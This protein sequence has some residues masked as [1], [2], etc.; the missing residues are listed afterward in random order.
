MAGGHSQR[1]TASTITFKHIFNTEE[2]PIEPL[3]CLLNPPETVCFTLLIWLSF[4]LLQSRQIPR[5]CS[6]FSCVGH[7]IGW[8]FLCCLPMLALL[9]MPYKSKLAWLLGLA[10]HVPSV[11]AYPHRGSGQCPLKWASLAPC[12]IVSLNAAPNE[13]SS[14]AALV[15]LTSCIKL[16]LRLQTYSSSL[17][18]CPSVN[19]DWKKLKSKIYFTRLGVKL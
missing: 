13:I 12:E 6:L 14:S 5:D 2:N 18:N 17:V 15:R 1:P 4:L 8:G 11:E 16:P 9:T 10:G 7:C 3:L 19:V